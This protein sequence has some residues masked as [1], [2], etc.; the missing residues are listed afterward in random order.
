VSAR[1]RGR[2]FYN[3]TNA[4]LVYKINISGAEGARQKAWQ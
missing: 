1:K 2:F 4:A 3:Q